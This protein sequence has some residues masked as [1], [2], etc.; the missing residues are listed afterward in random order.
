MSISGRFC[1]CDNNS[2]QK[3]RGLLCSGEDHGFC[4]CGKCTCLDG[5]EGPACECLNKID[6]CINP[7]SA[8]GE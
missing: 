2:C 3:R 6:T 1:E 4:E 7:L 8:D 5:W